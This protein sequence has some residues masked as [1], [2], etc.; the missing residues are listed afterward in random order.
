MITRRPGPLWD[1]GDVRVLQPVRA[2]VGEAAR[3]VRADAS[4]LREQLGPI[5]SW[6]QGRLPI[7]VLVVARICG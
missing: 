1:V 7:G 2:V 3:Q 6:I 5:G 4:R